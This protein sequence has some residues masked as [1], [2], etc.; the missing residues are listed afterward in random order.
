MSYRSTIQIGIRSALLGG[1]CVVALA[2]TPALAQDDQSGIETVTVT[3]LRAS[4]QRSLDIKRDSNGIVD[5]I[6]A[7]DIGKFP[8]RNLADAMMRIPGVTVTR[9]GGTATGGTGGVSTNGEATEIT[10]RGFG[11]TFNETL[12]DGREVATGTGD[13]AF[14]FSS[15]SSDFVS[16]IDVLK[17]PDASL[18]A[19]AIGA[20]INVQ[21]PKPFDH[22]GLVV[23]SSLSA[24]ES[25]EANKTTPN[26]DF[27]IS[28]TF[29]NDTIGFLVAGS[30][31]DLQ[32]RQ[33]HINIQG[34]EGATTVANG[35]SG[36][37]QQS[38]FAGTPPPVGAPNWFIQDYGIYHELQDTKREQ[39]R[40]VLQW[41][42]TSAVE[43]TLND[44]FSRET[45]NQDQY[46]YSVWFNSGSM[47]NI[48]RDSSGTITDFTQAST[49]D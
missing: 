34:W 27:L 44:N 30:Y 2:S 13:R 10:V 7:E 38:Q 25:P 48:A 43:I 1:A 47:Q 9:Q 19:G 37:F 35:A 17:S 42:P 32:T 18:S 4:L 41:R 39:A 24:E 8:D 22:P 40:V 14:D 6:T 29:D 28:D 20:T 11:P 12:F 21:F 15:V 16:R 33:N 23:A 3:G 49:P 46:G 45:Q 36:G 5:A 31:S 26:G